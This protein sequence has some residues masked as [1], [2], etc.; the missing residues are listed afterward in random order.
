[1][2][3]FTQSPPSKLHAALMHSPSQVPPLLFEDEH[4]TE[5]AEA[6]SRER[7]APVNSAI[8]PPSLRAVLCSALSVCPGCT[9]MIVSTSAT[10][11][12]DDAVL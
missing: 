10:A 4:T 5:H 9:M 7:L 11:P 2:R 6:S 1:M 12:P 3:C 8:A